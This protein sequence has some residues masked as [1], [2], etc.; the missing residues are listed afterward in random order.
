MINRFSKNS[1]DNLLKGCKK[2][3]EIQKERRRVRI[4]EYNKNPKKC[5]YCSNSIEYDKKNSNVFCNHSCAASFNNKGKRRNYSLGTRPEKECLYCGTI[6]KNIKFCCLGCSYKYRLEQRRKAIKDGNKIFGN[7]DKKYLIEDRGH[8]CE[9][10]NTEEWLEK[11]ILL[12]MDHIDGNSDNNSLNNVRVICSNCD[13]TLD[14]YKAR[15]KNK[16][17][18]SKR[19]IYRQNRYSNGSC[20]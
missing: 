12:I 15:N 18:D 17:R 13:A 2:S 16:G 3:A 6:S 14:T 10:C 4:N 1:Y 7:R 9:I 8:K 11:P 5:K 20:N 19:K